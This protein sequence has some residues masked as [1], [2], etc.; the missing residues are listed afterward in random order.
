MDS[1][2]QPLDNWGKANNCLSISI[3]SEKLA[4]KKFTYRNTILLK[5]LKL[6]VRAKFAL[7]NFLVF[8]FYFRFSDDIKYM[9]N[10]PPR[11]I[12]RWC[13]KVISPVSIFAVLAMSIRGMSKDA[14]SYKTWDGEKVIEEED[15]LE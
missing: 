12:W 10:K 13:W 3:K 2:A 15:D 6:F 7:L 1:D 5:T 9:T 8:S 11:F 4:D 14:P